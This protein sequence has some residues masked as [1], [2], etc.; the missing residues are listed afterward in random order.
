MKS[1]FVNLLRGMAVFLMLWGHCIQYCMPSGMDFFENTIFKII[2]SFH[3]PLFTLISGYL[4]YFSFEKRQ[5]KELLKRRCFGLLQTIICCGLF[6]YLLSSGIFSILKGDFSWVFR[7]RWAS[8]FL[9]LWFVWSILSASIVVG[10]VCKLINI[11]WLKIVLLLVGI[12]IVYLFPCGEMN[13]FMYPY[14]LIGFYFNKYKNKLPKKLINVKLLSLV[15]FP[16]ILIFF[17]KQHYIYTS[18]LFGKGYGI[19][20]YIKIDLFRW[21]AGLIGSVFLITVMEFIYKYLVVKKEKFFVFKWL[22]FLGEKSLQT[23]AL[24]VIF[25]SAYLPLVYPLLIGL[26]PEIE[27]FF[28]KNIWI[29]NLGF[30]LIL[31]IIYSVLIGAIV[32]LLEICKLNKILF[33][34]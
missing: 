4:F 8:G 34:R 16:L 12:V 13:A 22:N 20:E 26:A 18:G 19:I 9:Q 25:L 33:G 7:L 10:L 23:Y 5:L 29:Y 6:I 14:F 2:Y 1:S 32:K 11:K 27:L 28:V 21:C 24:S 30:T 31:G 15:L 17:D 3:M